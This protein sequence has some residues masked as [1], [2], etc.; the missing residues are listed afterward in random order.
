LAGCPNWGDVTECPSE[1]KWHDWMSIPR[2]NQFVR[3]MVNSST[4]WQAHEFT[5]HSNVV[6][7][8]HWHHRETS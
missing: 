2:L 3:L 1:V 5:S 6:I 8:A 4:F 7:Q